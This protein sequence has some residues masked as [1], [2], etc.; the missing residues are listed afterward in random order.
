MN[1]KHEY[2]NQLEDI[3]SMP[4]LIDLLKFVSQDTDHEMIRHIRIQQMLLNSQNV[5]E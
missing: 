3:D 4:S 5:I 2:L 1:P